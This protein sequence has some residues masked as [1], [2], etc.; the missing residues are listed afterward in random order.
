MKKTMYAATIAIAASIALSPAAQAAQITP[1][2]DG[3]GNIT[4]PGRTQISF[5]DTNT[6]F[7]AGTANEHESR[8]GLSLVK[9]YIAEYIVKHGDP[10]DIP[11]AQ[12]MIR[13]SDDNIASELYAKYPQSISTTA[14]EYGLTD[15]HA[16]PHWGNSTTSSADTNKFIVT[17]QK[18]D[19]QSPVLIAMTQMSPV[20]ADGYQQDYGTSTLPGVVGSKLGWSDDRSSFHGSVSFGNGYVVSANTNGTKQQ[21][22]NDVQS[23]F[24]EKAPSVPT[25]PAVDDIVSSVE[26]GSSQG[27]L[28]EIPGV[29]WVPANKVAQQASGIASQYGIPVDP[30]LINQ[31]P[32][33]LIPV[34]AGSIQ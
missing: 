19:P 30:A 26:N 29:E 24:Q 8:Q 3:N 7:H 18:T 21:H 22:T 13:Y 31:V 9:L 17:K 23:A 5:D 10:A 20:A 34:P 12:Q 33:I 25:S 11:K 32:P 2:L 6:G 16:A 14:N 28:P 15:T 1:N 27:N 4:A